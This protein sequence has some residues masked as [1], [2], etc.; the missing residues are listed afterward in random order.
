MRWSGLIW[1]AVAIPSGVGLGAGLWL[2]SSVSYDHGIWPIGAILRI[3]VGSIGVGLIIGF[4]MAIAMVF[5]TSETP[6]ER[7][8]R[9]SGWWLP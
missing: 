9:K 1:M 7:R 3:M 4:V 5:S 8:R 2:L 6:E